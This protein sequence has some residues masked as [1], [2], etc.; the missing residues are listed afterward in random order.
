MVCLFPAMLDSRKI[1]GLA[2]SAGS[3]KQARLEPSLVKLQIDT[4]TNVRYDRIEGRL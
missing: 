1:T 3:L 4:L 2:Y